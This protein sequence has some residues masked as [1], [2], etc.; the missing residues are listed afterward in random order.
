[1]PWSIQWTDQA[2]R[3]LS[4]QDRPVARRVVAKLEMAA[5]NP[6]QH[7]VRLVASDDFKF[8]I[9]DY[10]PLAAL[11]HD[12]RTIIVQRVDHR[13]NVYCRKP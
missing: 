13:R 12:N 5:G 1:M 10:R 11:S 8:R 4:K 6:S 7:F 9:G 3:D 2:L